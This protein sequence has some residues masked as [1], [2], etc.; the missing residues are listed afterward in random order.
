[1]RAVRV[2]QAGDVR[3]HVVEQVE[4]RFLVALTRP[5]NAGRGLVG[6]QFSALH[7][8]L[9]EMRPVLRPAGYK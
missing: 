4:D 1:M 9:Q 3:V 5:L 8:H 2:D 7:N 6:G